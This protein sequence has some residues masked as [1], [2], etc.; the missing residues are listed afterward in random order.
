MQDGAL[1]EHQKAVR[2]KQGCVID[3]QPEYDAAAYAIVTAFN[4]ISRGR[5]YHQ[6]GH[7]KPIGLIEIEGYMRLFPVP[8]PLWIF[9]DCILQLDDLFLDAIKTS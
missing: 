8:V 6:T 3:D 4:R 1:T 2:R 5:G 7:P 9:C